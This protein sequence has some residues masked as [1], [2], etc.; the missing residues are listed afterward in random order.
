MTTDIQA[1][2]KVSNPSATEE[3]VESEAVAALILSAIND[4]KPGVSL[5]RIYS[6]LCQSR[7]ESHLDPLSILPHLLPCPQPAAK[8]LIALTGECGSPKE[9]VIAVQESLERV[10]LSLETDGDE[11]EDDGTSESPSNQLLSLISLYN[12]AIPRLKLRKKSPSE[13]IRPLLSQ[14]ESTIQLASSRL[15]RD[16]GR[17]IIS[18]LAR[19]SLN[20]VS[21]A[22]C[23]NIED[24]AVCR[25]IATSLLDTAV[26]ACSH[27]IQS[28]LAQRSFEALYPRL[29]IKSTVLPGWEGGDKAIHDALAVYQTFGVTLD[30]DSLPPPP[31]ATYL[32]LLSHSKYLPSDIGHLLSFILPV[33]VVSIQANYALDEALSLLL[34]I[35]HSSHFPPGRQMSLDIS[36]CLCAL[37]PSLASAHPDG[38]VR[39]QAFRILS[40][41]LALTPPELR[42]EILRDL[43]TDTA[44][45]QM[46]VAA[47]GL[48]KEAAL[49]FLSHDGPSVFASPIFLQV[50][51]PILLRPDPI[52]LFHPPDLS[53]HDIEDSSEPARLVECLSLY[54]VLLLRDTSNRTGI[55]DQD[56]LWNIE[57]TLLAPLR[58]TLSRWMEDPTLSNEHVH[59]IMPL[60]SLKTSLERV[61]SAVANLRA[62]AKV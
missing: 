2:L 3:I 53:L 32:I 47:V 14:L 28:S 39:H 57:K 48:V 13:T 27:C 46:R 62:E 4:E 44:F 59:A 26:S 45:P 55:H 18:D 6:V 33:L 35:S 56:Q 24:A 1:L 17:E 54:Y 29:T 49:E 20:V 25:E 10:N 8:S 23:L 60:V 52:D 7:S 50:L 5:N 22:Q 21:W 9:V 30:F 58:A 38:D 12:S 31:S 19:L 40:R 36:G 16:Q 37:L 43:T 42:L 34:H 41:V 61:D 15:S 51:G 11:T